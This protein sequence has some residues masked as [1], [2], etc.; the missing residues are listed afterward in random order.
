MTNAKDQAVSA[1]A[2]AQTELQKAL[3]HLERMP[4]FDPGNVLLSAHALNNYL[5][6]VSG[7]TELLGLK[8]PKDVDP[9]VRT[10]LDNLEH[11][12][13]VMDKMGGS[14]RCESTVQVGS[15]FTFRVPGYSDE[16]SS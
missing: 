1:I 10:L 14:I 9:A 4:T 6:V 13:V 15:S 16:S 3:S 2:A 8:L 11:T 5:S 7:I 12:N